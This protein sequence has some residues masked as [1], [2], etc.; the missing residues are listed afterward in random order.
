MEWKK[1]ET[2]EECKSLA[3]G[4][5]LVKYPVVGES[6]HNLNL[7]DTANLRYG[8]V[9]AHE[10]AQIIIKLLAGKDVDTSG[11]ALLE[12]EEPVEIEQLL[13][14]QMWWFRKHS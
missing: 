11:N 7:G 13:R 2:I 1:I 3:E 14:E 9:V 8:K 5:E 10:E 6:V 12:G 4:D